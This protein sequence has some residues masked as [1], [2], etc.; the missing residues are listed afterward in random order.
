MQSQSAALRADEVAASARL[1]RTRHG[2]IH[3]LAESPGNGSSSNVSTM[4]RLAGD[5]QER[6]L[7]WSTPRMPA[8]RVC[9]GEKGRECRMFARARNCERR[10]SNSLKERHCDLG[11]RLSRRAERSRRARLV[12]GRSRRR[13][14][15]KRSLRSCKPQQRRCVVLHRQRGGRGV[16]Q[17]KW[18]EK[19]VET[20]AKAA[21]PIKVRRSRRVCAQRRRQQ[22]LWQRVNALV[23]CVCDACPA[24]HWQ[25]GR[26]GHARE[27]CC[28]QR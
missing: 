18:R 2:F 12:G 26:E 17:P 8:C 20:H 27:G 13:G 3:R 22:R 9:V 23:H 11:G 1:K 21:I 10:V 28:W 4:G 25:R 6:I 15:A 16:V 19:C 14:G 24:S 7:L 5:R